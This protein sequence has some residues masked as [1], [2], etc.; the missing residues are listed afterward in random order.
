[1]RGH[2]A[3]GLATGVVFGGALLALN[4]QAGIVGIGAF[5]TW[6][7]NEL[8]FPIGCALVVY[9]SGVPGTADA[10]AR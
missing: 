8:L 2:A 3:V 9:Q 4:V 1:M 7:V 10:K 5:L 6:L